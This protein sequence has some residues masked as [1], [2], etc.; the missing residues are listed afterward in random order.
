MHSK[1]RDTPLSVDREQAVAKS[2][3]RKA[4]CEYYP[5]LSILVAYMLVAV[6]IGPYSNGDTAW[7]LD[8]VSGVLKYGMPYAGGF[9]LMDQPPIGFYIQALFFN[10]FGTSINNGT[11]LVTLFGLG[12]IPLVYYIGST[13][14]NRTTGYFAALLFA[15][16]PWHLILA[17]TFLIDTQ[18]LFF[19]LLCLA[20]GVAAFRRGS[21][22]LFVAS[23]VVFAVAFNTKLYAVFVLLPLLALFLYRRP[24]NVKRMLGWLAAF[25]VPVLVSSFLWYDVVADTGLHSIVFHT[26]FT[27]QSAISVVPSPFFVANFLINYGL[28]WFF[29]D[30]VLLSLVL[31][32]AQRRLFRKYLALDAVCLALIVLVVFVNMVL[33]IGLNLKAPY[34]NAIKYDY[35]ALPF[36]SLIAAALASKSLTLL[37]VAKEKIKPYKA[38]F[39]VAGLLG[40]ILVAASVLYNMRFVNLFSTAEYLILRVEPTVVYGYSLFNAAPIGTNSAL[41][42]VQYVGFAVA[43]S[44]LAWLGREK[45]GKLAHLHTKR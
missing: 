32:L 44:G 21:F 18:C 12:C 33:G 26:D 6:S 3:M 31:S 43:L 30:A 24:I 19:S 5:L 28:G 37:G 7:E 38:V 35:Q 17:R 29:V 42:A 22:K 8:A 16:S 41:M 23:G 2:T 13:L 40:L 39:A 20:F 1:D 27:V 45:L 25:A 9:Y 15:L 34:L 4:L 14:Y 11:F 10:A 36:F